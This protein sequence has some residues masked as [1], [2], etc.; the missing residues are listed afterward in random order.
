[1]F[2][3]EGRDI[4]KTFT[5]RRTVIAI[6]VFSNVA[7]FIERRLSLMILFIIF[8][9]FLKEIS[10]KRSVGQKEKEISI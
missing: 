4:S 10:Y 9:N 5:G 1:L 2:E 8:F 3:N 6:S 7:A